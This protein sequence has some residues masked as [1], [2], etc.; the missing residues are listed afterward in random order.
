VPFCLRRAGGCHA[1]RQIIKATPGH[2]NVRKL[3]GVSIRLRRQRERYFREHGNSPADCA[4]RQISSRHSPFRGG[5]GVGNAAGICGP[6]PVR[7]ER[8]SW[9]ALRVEGWR[10]V[11]QGHAMPQRE[12]LARTGSTRAMMAASGPVGAAG[13]AP[14]D[15]RLSGRQGCKLS[16]RGPR[17]SAS[18]LPAAGETKNNA[19]QNAY[20]RL[21]PGGNAGRRRPR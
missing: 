3:P 6:A 18:A 21:P 5:L 17:W 13:G 14:A 16:A 15:R 8:N 7:E 1:L 2:G 20:R 4:I 10:M 9:P 19:E 12:L 11:P